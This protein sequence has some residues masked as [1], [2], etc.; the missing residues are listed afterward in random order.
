MI[1]TLIFLLLVGLLGLGAAWLADRPGDILV[2][3]Q[4]YRI[5]TSLGVGL[6]GLAL[7]ALAF[8]LLWTLA[9][10]IFRIPAL[11][12]FAARGRRQSKG[13][14][15]LSRGLVAVGA[16]HVQDARQQA[17]EAQRLLGSVEPAF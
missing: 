5:E 3:W 12:A 17:R 9:R 1:R 16:G 4:G 11:L 7:V 2:N 8:M 15:A 10:F 6:A 13:Y 14:A